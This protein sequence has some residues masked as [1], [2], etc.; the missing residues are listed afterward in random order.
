MIDAVSVVCIHL[1]EAMMKIEGADSGTIFTGMAPHRR[2]IEL[3]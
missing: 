1:P 3:S 2:P